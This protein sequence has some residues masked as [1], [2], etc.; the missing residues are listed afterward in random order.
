MVNFS[1]GNANPAI[2]ASRSNVRMF[3]HL[4]L[5]FTSSPILVLLLLF[6][7]FFMVKIPRVNGGPFFRSL[8]F[9]QFFKRDRMYVKT[10]IEKLGKWLGHTLE[11]FNESYTSLYRISGALLD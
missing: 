8:S 11:A 6:F 2:F 9:T 10:K 3:I 5:T 1:R 7:S 4:F